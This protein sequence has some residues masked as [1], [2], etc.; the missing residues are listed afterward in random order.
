[1]GNLNE[2]SNRVN[3]DKISKG[4]DNE[5]NKKSK[6]NKIKKEKK[7]INVK[8]IF[9]RYKR[10]IV[11]GL[12]CVLLLITIII[13]L[14]SYLT[15]DKYK[16]YYKYE[17]K[18]D[19]YGYSDLYLN[20]NSN[21]FDKVTRIEAAKIVVASVLN[22]TDIEPYMY[23]EIGEYTDDKWGEYAEQF[24]ILGDFDINSEN[25]LD[26]VDYMTVV[27]YFK[28]AKDVFFKDVIVKDYTDKITGL[29]KYDVIKQIAVK[30]LL[31][32]NVIQIFNGK[33]EGDKIAIK[34]QLNEMAVNFANEFNTLAINNEKLNINPDN[35]PS[36]VNDYPYT[37][38]SVDKSIYEMPFIS[39]GGYT[40]KKPS[41]I[42][43]EY[44][45]NLKQIVRISEE[46][47]S[48]FLNIDY[49]TINAN[50][51]KEQIESCLN[52][53]INSANVEEYVKHV[54]ENKI[55]IS[56]SAKNII[57]IIYFDG[58]TTR[59]RMKI[60]FNV[61]NSNTTKNLLYYDSVSFANGVTYEDKSYEFYIDYPIS[62][63]F[64]LNY[65]FM[66]MSDIFS[67]I[68]M[69]QQVNINK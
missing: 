65:G 14:V 63:S 6:G 62:K 21:T 12:I 18:M 42:Y 35:Q 64:K 54:K 19:I 28:N 25:Y 7:P 33:F 68:A 8:K 44:S 31:G 16:E 29:N 3:I 67:S 66:E 40:E 34:G 55:K 59:V 60:N 4:V 5:I 49:N 39:S 69:N 45:N 24:G 37:L 9:K 27:S 17:G 53:S 13:A 2:N 61:E 46:Y 47:F 56:G 10:L 38:A 36:N 30:D 51:F 11:L 32:N 57:P 58:M 52:E 1:M 43:K 50:I 41:E 48:Y 26:E 22:I 15:K 23:N 20:R